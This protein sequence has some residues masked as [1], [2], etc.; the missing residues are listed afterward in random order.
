MWVDVVIM[1]NVATFHFD[2]FHNDI[3]TNNRTIVSDV[4]M[5]KMMFLSG[6]PKVFLHIHLRNRFSLCVVLQIDAA[7]FLIGI[8]NNLPICGGREGELD[9]THGPVPEFA[10]V[11]ICIRL[12]TK[13]VFVSGFACKAGLGVW[14]RNPS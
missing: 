10:T 2:I 7:G 12:P 3:S 8:R 5:L 6:S 11:N 14:T 9:Q 4:S 13:Q 1:G